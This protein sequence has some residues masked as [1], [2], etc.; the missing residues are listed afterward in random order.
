M[1]VIPKAM[2]KNV[3]SFAFAY[4]SIW[5]SS[6]S[7]CNFSPSNR[8]AIILAKVPYESKRWILWARNKNRVKSMI[9]TDTP[10]TGKVIKAT[11]RSPKA[12]NKRRRR[13]TIVIIKPINAR[14]LTY[15]SIFTYKLRRH[16]VI[17]TKTVRSSFNPEWCIF[18]FDNY[19]LNNRS[20]YINVCFSIAILS[21]QLFIVFIDTF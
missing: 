15:P 13:T 12:N 10:Q 17:L 3:A 2:L 16:F 20:H 14:I 4:E 11:R 6:R 8:T 1:D 21:P 18:I 5:D 7:Q 19:L 9:L